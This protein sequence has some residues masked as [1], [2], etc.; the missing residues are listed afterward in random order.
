M[1]Q[2][3]VYVCVCERER[4]RERCDRFFYEIQVE[5]DPLVKNENASTIFEKKSKLEKT[6]P[7]RAKAQ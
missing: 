3:C 2:M 1:C 7:E 6:L 5:G 4:E